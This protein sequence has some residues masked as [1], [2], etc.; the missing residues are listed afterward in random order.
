MYDLREIARGVRLVSVK[1]SD[2]KT[3]M[4]SVSMALPLN[5]NAAVN[6]LLL[7]LLKRS[8]K[9]YPDYTS[10]HKK[11]DEL[12]GASVFSSVSKN[13]D[14][15][16]LTLYAEC[17]DDRFSLDGK[18]IISETIDL[19]KDIIFRPNVENESF[20]DDKLSLEKRLL[21]ESIIEEQND[22]RAYAFKKCVE[23]MFND[24]PFG[25]NATG[26]CETVKNAEMSQ[27]YDAWKNM[28]SRAVIQITV[29]GNID[30]GIVDDSF[31]EDFSDI[32]RNPYDLKTIFKPVA[33][34]SRRI[35][36]T[37]A[38]NQ[39]KLVMGF[40][41]G[42]E[43]ANDN[44]YAVRVMTDIFGGGTHS[45][46][47]QNIR[48]KMSLAYY[49]SAGFVSTKG[50]IAVQSGIDTEKE[51]AVTQGVLE[52]LKDVADGKFEDSIIEASKRS[53]KEGFTFSSPDAICKYYT[54]QLLDENI[55]TPDEVIKKIEKVTKED[56][57]KAA[58]KVSLDTVFMLVA[59]SEEVNADEN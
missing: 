40:R 47:F 30:A 21:T 15:Q 38:A 1:A 59:D 35:E 44:Y 29:V 3:A 5:E 43:N 45:N 48:E 27:I 20:G 6:A 50:F 33:V 57:C 56:I 53:L 12:Y 42:T 9:A 23:H 31:K 4:I 51:G 39:G 22:K 10:L 32:D 8:C 46:L 41:A 34:E 36:E 28:L 2:Y 18:S 52:Q 49:C 7:N 55:E 54:S 11:L 37:V 24:E 26:T 16:V 14:A 17:L 13:G 58:E 19:L 25:I